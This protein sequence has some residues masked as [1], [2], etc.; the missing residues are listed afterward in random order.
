MRELGGAVGSCREQEGPAG[1]K[2]Q[3]GQGAGWTNDQEGAGSR[4]EHHKNGATSIFVHNKIP[5]LL[6]M[7][8][9]F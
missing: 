7:S 6:R 9:R 3:D 2:E 5:I 1:S 8:I 4:R